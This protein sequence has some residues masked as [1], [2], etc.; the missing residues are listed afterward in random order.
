MEGGGPGGIECDGKFALCGFD[1]FLDLGWVESLLYPLVAEFPGLVVDL[2][3]PGDPE[4]RV[5]AH[6][7]D[8]D[9][10]SQH[11]GGA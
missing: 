5:D 1:K 9:G 10:K 8:Y 2:W 3:I 4:V 6:Q 11:V 7:V